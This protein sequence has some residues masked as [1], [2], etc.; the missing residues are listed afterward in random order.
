MIRVIVLLF[1]VAV[2]GCHESNSVEP[3]LDNST[4]LNRIDGVNEII[5]NPIENDESETTTFLS[6]HDFDPDEG[7]GTIV[8]EKSL[9]YI[10]D[11]EV[12]NKY[13]YRHL[14][15]VEIVVPSEM[16]INNK[17]FPTEQVYLLNR[18][19]KVTSGGKV[20][21]GTTWGTFKIFSVGK[22]FNVELFSGEFTGNISLKTT[23]IVLKGKGVQGHYK[24]RYFLAEDEQIH[25][26][27]NGKLHGWISNMK[28]T[29]SQKVFADY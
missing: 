5:G 22:P 27:Q 23:K 26:S 29:I 16:V 11:K 24:D 25:T 3:V 8:G 21:S 17:V 4:R 19:E 2:I 14:I 6:K 18:E 10:I 13:T 12:K 1:S 20:V 15:D 28:G 7:R 9:E